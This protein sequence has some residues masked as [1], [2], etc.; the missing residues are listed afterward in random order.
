MVNADVYKCLVQSGEAKI[1]LL[2]L[3]NRYKTPHCV[4]D[5]LNYSADALIFISKN[6]KVPL[7]LFGEINS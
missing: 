3:S 1:G 5:Y 7:H 6:S 2:H 4:C